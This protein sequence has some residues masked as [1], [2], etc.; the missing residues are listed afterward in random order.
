MARAP[1]PARLVFGGAMSEIQ[2]CLWFDREAEEAARFYASLFPGSSVRVSSRYG[3]GMPLPEGTPL[4]VEFT[5]YGRTYQALNGGPMYKLTEAFS[6]SVLCEDQAEV[7]RLWERL[8]DGGAPSRC[9]WLED[10]FGLSW[11]IVPRTLV[12]LQQ[13][14]GPGVGRMFAAMMGMTKLDGPALERAYHGGGPGDG[15]PEGGDRSG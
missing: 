7:D 1:A 11:Q 8:C 15:A 4:I 12:R 6:L 2:P 10:R 5:L 14:G 9:G 3:P 13:Q